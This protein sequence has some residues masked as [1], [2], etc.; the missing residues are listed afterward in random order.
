MQISLENHALY[1]E[2]P[3]TATMT[4]IKVK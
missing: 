3:F 1:T 2:N 4:V